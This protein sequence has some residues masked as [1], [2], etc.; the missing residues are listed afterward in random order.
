M[1]I[2][3]IDY[4]VSRPHSGFGLTIHGTLFATDNHCDYLHH[5]LLLVENRV[6]F[7]DLVAVEG[8][9]VC[10]NLDATHAQYRKVRGKSSPVKLSQAEYY[11]HDGCDGPRNPQIVEIRL[12]HQSVARSV[13]TAIAPFPSVIRAMLQALP[14]GLQRNLDIRRFRDD[15][16]KTEFWNFQRDKFV[17]QAFGDTPPAKCSIGD[18]ANAD[19]SQW[20]KIQGQIIRL[21]RREMEAESCREFYREV[22][23]LAA[24]FVQPWRMGESRLMLNDHFRAEL[25]MQHRRAQQG[26]QQTSDQNGHLVKRWPVEEL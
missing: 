10:L 17:T 19:T 11:H 3:Q 25:T 22:D 15:F 13:A 14:K 16:E 7:Y 20:H 1:S 18:T 4:V 2:G 24:A 12:P 9:V 5:H 21:V 26:N 8:L 23:R 6:A